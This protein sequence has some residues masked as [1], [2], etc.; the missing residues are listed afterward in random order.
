MSHFLLVISIISML[1]E[2]MSFGKM[3]LEYQWKY[4]DLL[5][6]SPQQKQEA[7]NSGAYN[8][9]IA[10]LYDIDKAPGRL[11]LFKDFIVILYGNTSFFTLTILIL[12]VIEVLLYEFNISNI[13]QI[14]TL[15]L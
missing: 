9:S 3:R 8:A 13:I 12:N 14:I 15:L 10:F 2:T 7:I 6:D 4:L 11:T 5:W 1:M